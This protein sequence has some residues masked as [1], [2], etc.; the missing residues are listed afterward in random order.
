MAEAIEEDRIKTDRGPFELGSLCLIKSFLVLKLTK[1]SSHIK[2][3]FLKIC[4]V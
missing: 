2:N 3:I 4:K 1:L